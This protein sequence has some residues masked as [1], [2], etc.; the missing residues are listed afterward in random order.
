AGAPS[1][2][3]WPAVAARR[4]RG[5]ATTGKPAATTA[6][7][8]ATSQAF[9]SRR[10]APGRGNDRSWSHWLW[11]S[12]VCAGGMRKT[13]LGPGA[14]GQFELRDPAGDRRTAAEA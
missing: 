6:L 12:V 3:P 4:A 9:G 8:V 10:G 13:L 11:G 1:G 7:A 5:V 2:S 14:A